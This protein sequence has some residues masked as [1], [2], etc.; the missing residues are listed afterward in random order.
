MSSGKPFPSSSRPFP[1]ISPGFVHAAPARSGWLKSTP[2]SMTATTIDRIAL[3]DPERLEAVDVDVGDAGLVLCAIEVLAGVVEAPLARGNPARTWDR[4][5]A[6]GGGWGPPR[7]RA[8]RR[9]GGAGRWLSTGRRPTTTWVRPFLLVDTTSRPRSRGDGAALGE[10]RVRAV[11]H[12]DLIRRRGRGGRV[13]CGHAGRGDQAG[14]EGDRN[15][16]RRDGMRASASI[17]RRSVVRSV[18]A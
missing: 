5:R 17:V 15:Q 11:A 13:C 9:R 4:R 12:E 10:S 14:G 6:R 1:A 7:G 3:R 8:G 18:T 16:D 2:S